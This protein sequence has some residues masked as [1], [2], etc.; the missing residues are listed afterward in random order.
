MTWPNVTINQLNQ[1]QGKINEV[2]RTVL[3]VGNA[4]T[5]D[6]DLVALN[7]QSDI[8]T[9]LTDASEAL[10]EVVRAAKVNAGQN[11][12]AYALLVAAGNSAAT[13]PSA[14]ESVQD[15][16]SVEGVVAVTQLADASEGRTTIEAFSALR[17]TLVS[18]L[19]R[20][21]WFV[22]TA[23][24]PLTVPGSG[25]KPGVTWADYLKFQS[26][27]AKDIAAHAVQLVPSLW[28]NEAGVLAGRLCN[29]SVTIADSPARVKTGA[30]VGLGIESSDLPVDSAGIEL[31]L[32]QLRAMHDLRYSVPMWYPDYEGIYWA[33]GL[34]LDVKGGDY[35]VIEYLR[36]VDKA[37][38]RVRIQAI[39]KIGDRSLNSTPASIASHKTYFSKTLREMSRST[40]INGVTFPGEV[41][42]PQEG[43]VEITWTD[44]ETVQIYLVVR[45]YES[46]KSITV[47]IMLDSSL[48]A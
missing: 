29:R 10:R 16:I 11:W 7:S 30:I 15:L 4:A 18:K 48:E 26:A 27:L 43:D 36:I 42:P 23:S 13:W 22:L 28:G 35:P 38:R 19:G 24:G 20:W 12:Q 37:A 45:P 25:A 17:E 9:A 1:R 6:G 33:D 3:F 5:G 34:T 44:T 32:A 46:P 31:D 39:A 40:Q 2:E 21:V 41:K 8:D 14:I 47:S